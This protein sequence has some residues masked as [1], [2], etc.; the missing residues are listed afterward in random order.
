MSEAVLDYE[1]SI[2][3]I[4]KYFNLG[5]QWGDAQCVSHHYPLTAVKVGIVCERIWIVQS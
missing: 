5:D 2:N 3:S 4:T 1:M